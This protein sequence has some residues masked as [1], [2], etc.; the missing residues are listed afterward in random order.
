MPEADF[1]DP[2][3]FLRFGR[4]PRAVDILAKIDGMDFETAWEN[5]IDG[6]IDRETALKA[7]F[8]SGSDL[9]IAK[10]A[11]GKP[12]DIADTVAIRTAAEAN[13]GTR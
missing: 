12:Q 9:I 13:H 11:A 5:R 3:T 6:V 2:Q 10:L 4:E 7:R 1:C 8:I